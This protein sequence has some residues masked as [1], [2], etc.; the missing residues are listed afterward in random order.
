MSLRDDLIKQNIDEINSYA[1]ILN[2]PQKQIFVKAIRENNLNT[3]NVLVIEVRKRIAERAAV[4][5][6]ECPECHKF[7]TWIGTLKGKRVLINYDTYKVEQYYI[8]SKHTCHW[9][10]C[11]YKAPLLKGVTSD[12][13]RK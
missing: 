2:T 8:P 10:E 12:G 4:D 11:N 1:D 13:T 7:V 3:L 9:N 5:P 6:F